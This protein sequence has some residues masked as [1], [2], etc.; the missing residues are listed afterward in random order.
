[1]SQKL[2]IPVTVTPTQGRSTEKTVEVAPSGASVKEICKAGGIDTKNKDFAVN[3]KPATL[4]THVG[5]SDAIEA[6][7]RGKPAVAVSERPQ[8]S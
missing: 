4:D 1:M 3:G 8:G 6:K 2:R 7:D 5:P